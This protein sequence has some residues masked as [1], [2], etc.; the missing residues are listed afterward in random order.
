MHD[1][2]KNCLGSGVALRTPIPLHTMVKKRCLLVPRMVV[3]ET[4]D[5]KKYCVGSGV[6]LHPPIPLHSMVQR[7]CFWVPRMVVF[8]MHDA[9]NIVWVLGWRSKHPYL[10]TPWARK[11]VSG[12]LGWGSLKCTRPKKYCVGSGVALQ[13]PIPLHTMAQKG[14]FCGHLAWWR[15]KR[16][17]PKKYCVGSGVAL[18][19]PPPLHTLGQK[20]CLPVPRMVVFEI[21]DAKRYCVGSGVALQPPIPL[22]TMGQKRC[23]PVPRMV[24][25]EMHNAKKS[26]WVLGWRSNHPYFCTPRARKG[27]SE[28]MG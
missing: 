18:Q 11:G 10:C 16:T 27:L 14:F 23:L 12:H 9:K 26:Q 25:F 24:V 6:A 8:E 19:P 3:F 20:R 15:L 17:M 13:T 7:S 4:C 5:A 28:Y 21:Y 22:H 2:K 1:A